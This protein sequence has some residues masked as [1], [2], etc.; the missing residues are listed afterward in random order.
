M[1]TGYGNIFELLINRTP[2]TGTD[3]GIS[4][5]GNKCTFSHKITK[6][7]LAKSQRRKEEI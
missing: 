1:V 4:P 5:D 2:L 6:I 3:K 7:K